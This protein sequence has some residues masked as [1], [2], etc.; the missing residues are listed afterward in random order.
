MKWHEI[1]TGTIISGKDADGVPYLKL[2][3]KD[4]KQEFNV[5]TVNAACQKCI[6]TYHNKFIK[7]YRS[8]DNKCKYVL[9]KKR[10]GL[11]LKFGSSIFV[12]NKNITDDYAKQLIKR[13]KDVIPNFEL[14]YLFDKYPVE[15][16]KVTTE[17]V[18]PKKRGRK[19]KKQ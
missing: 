17:E 1:D 19:P 2:F 16:V 12:N 6:K 7:K 3:L 18:K 13:F 10:E 15:E 11:Q 14:S 5:D 9:H 8:M 4:Y